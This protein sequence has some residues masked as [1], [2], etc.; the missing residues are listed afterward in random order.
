MLRII[1]L[2][3]FILYRVIY[4]DLLM[5]IIR[6]GYNMREKKIRL[7]FSNEF[8]MFNI[9]EIEFPRKDITYQ[10]TMKGFL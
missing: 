3:C 1:V 2:Y 10:I 6:D 8:A 7:E 4:I 5:T 9:L